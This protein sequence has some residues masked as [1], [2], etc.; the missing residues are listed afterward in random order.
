VLTRPRQNLEEIT[1]GDGSAMLERDREQIMKGVLKL[2][3]N[4]GHPSNRILTKCLEH[5]SCA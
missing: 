2:R 4:M 5:T 3:R 1:W